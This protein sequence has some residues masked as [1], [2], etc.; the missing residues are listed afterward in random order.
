MLHDQP[1]QRSDE[2]K[3]ASQHPSDA[4]H[5]TQVVRERMR[6]DIARASGGL[7]SAHRALKD[8]LRHRPDRKP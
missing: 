7:E 8:W 3:P 6:E 2:R 4:L 5:E 1:L